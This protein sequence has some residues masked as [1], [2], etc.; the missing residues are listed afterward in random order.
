MI[1]ARGLIAWTFAEVICKVLLLC[2]ASSFVSSFASSHGSQT[3]TLVT[4]TGKEVVSFAL[5]EAWRV[6]SS[7]RL[8]RQLITSSFCSAS[9][10]A[11]SACWFMTANSCFVGSSSTEASNESH[12]QHWTGCISTQDQVLQC[13]LLVLVPVCFAT[14]L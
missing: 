12:H 2:S 8:R 6:R 11:C 14:V 4:R 9:F 3:E 13:F 5:S 7:I 1:S 10:R